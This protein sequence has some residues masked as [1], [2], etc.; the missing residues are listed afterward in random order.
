MVS[1]RHARPYT[2]PR[3]GKAW[4]VLQ[5]L[6]AL[7][8]KSQHRRG[9][10]YRNPSRADRRVINWRLF[11]VAKINELALRAAGMGNRHFIW[12]SS[13]EEERWFWE[14]EAEISK[15]SSPT[16]NLLKPILNLLTSRHIG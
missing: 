5:R 10:R 2:S 6:S 7:C 9:L 1:R 3:N 15:F 16:N 11:I 13:S 12:G 14:P 4:S 8:Y